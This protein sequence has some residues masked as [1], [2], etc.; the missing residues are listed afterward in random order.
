MGMLKSATHL[1]IVA[2]IAAGKLRDTSSIGFLEN[3]LGD[4]SREVRLA[5]IPRQGL[6]LLSEQGE[7]AQ[8]LRTM[9]SR[10]FPHTSRYT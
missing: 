7:L 9:S 4:P 6:I 5:S 1:Q 10:I 2:S 8:I 3:V